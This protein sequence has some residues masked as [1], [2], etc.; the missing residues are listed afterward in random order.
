MALMMPLCM[1]LRV[2]FQDFILPAVSSFFIKLTKLNKLTPIAAQ[3]ACKNM[4]LIV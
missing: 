1:R 4:R 2:A 3:Y